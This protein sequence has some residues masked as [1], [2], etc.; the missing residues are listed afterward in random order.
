MA[1]SHQALVIRSDGML[2]QWNSQTGRFDEI[3]DFRLHETSTTP[4]IF[5]DIALAPNGT[6]YAVGGNAIYRLDMATGLAVK[7]HDLFKIGN[8][9]DIRPDGSFVI[10]YA[11]R[12]YI[13]ILRPG[14]FEVLERYET[15]PDAGI[16]G[17]PG[18]AGDLQ[19]VGNRAYLTTDVDT[20]LVF[21]LRDGTIL[22]EIEN[23]QAGTAYGLHYDGGLIAFIGDAAY[24]LVDGEFRLLQ[25]FELD[26]IING[27]ATLP[28]FTRSGN[29]GNNTL[30]GSFWNDRLL[31][32]G[33]ADTLRGGN[34]ADTL[35]G[36]AGDDRLEGG[37]GFDRLLGGTGADRLLGGGGSD[38]LEGGAGNDTLIGAEGTDTLAGG[39]GADL[40]TGGA[41]A[42]RFVFTESGGRD[43]ITDFNVDLDQLLLDRDL[44]DGLT[45]PDRIVAEHA[46]L[47]NG[48]VVLDFGDTIIRLD[49]LTSLDGLADAISLI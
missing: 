44:L 35:D 29:A 30:T 18:S 15:D 48:A 14:T 7:V 27:A 23:A 40:L 25:D 37:A 28:S 17:G 22:Q 1:Q 49:G 10:G 3:R 43:R 5:F 47:V 4:A 16:F 8:A 12:D 6:L 46:R 31:G 38:R 26:T 21:D 32:Q 39:F 11:S 34:G 42:D 45:N 36:G 20:V 13:E 41:G 33:G 24:R 19:V 9:L 2:C